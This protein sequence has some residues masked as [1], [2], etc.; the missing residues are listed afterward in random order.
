MPLDIPENIFDEAPQVES[1][2]SKP[3]IGER[4]KQYQAA[5]RENGRGAPSFRNGMAKQLASVAT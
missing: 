1:E 2:E 3:N 5:K 4:Y